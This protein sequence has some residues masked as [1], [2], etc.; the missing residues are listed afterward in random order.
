VKIDASPFCVPDL[1]DLD[2]D[3]FADDRSKREDGIEFAAG[4]IDERPVRGQRVRVYVQVHNRGHTAAERVAVR[5]FFVPGGVTLPSLPA[6]F[7]N[8]FPNNVVPAGA[9][10][11]PVAP[12]RVVRRIAPGRAAVVGF[13]WTVPSTLGSAVGL[14]AV[15]SA[16]RDPITDRS[17]DVGSL[18][19]S[20]RH[21]ALRN[22]AVINP[23]PIA[24]PSS[25]TIVVDAWRERGARLT[26]D[27]QARRLVRGLVLGPTLAA[28]ARRARWAATALTDADLEHLTRAAD[29]RPELRPRLRRA[30]SYLPTPQSE[31]LDLSRLAARASEPIVLLLRRATSQPAGSL[32]VLDADDAPIG[33]LTIVNLRGARED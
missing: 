9:R 29:A 22:F 27:R 21:C 17:L 7:W 10:W 24:G 30:R 26:L 18:V 11:Q 13:E 31:G 25:H 4:L 28:E 14:L 16:A 32:L 33:G 20:S 15:A 1:D 5:A 23:S 8:A 2:V 6:G 19:R 3:L 12:H